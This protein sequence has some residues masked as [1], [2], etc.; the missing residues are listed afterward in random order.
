MQ[1]IESYIIIEFFEW[2]RSR[3]DGNKNMVILREC[4]FRGRHTNSAY[5]VLEPL[6]REFVREMDCPYQSW[7][8][9]QNLKY[10]LNS[11]DVPVK[12]Y[13]KIQAELWSNKKGSVRSPR[14]ENVLHNM[15]STPT[16]VGVEIE[17]FEWIEENRIDPVEI[18]K[19][20]KE[21]FEEM[22]NAFARERNRR[23]SKNLVEKLYSAFQMDI[24]SKQ[25]I[26]YSNSNIV[27]CL[28]LQLGANKTFPN[29]IHNYWDDLHFL[30]KDYLD[31]FY[32]ES[33]LWKSGYIVKEYIHK[34]HVPETAIP[35]LVLWRETIEEAL[36]I[37]LFDLEE[38]EVFQIIQLIV[39]MLK[40][41]YDLE[42]V[43]RETKNMADKK[44]AEKRHTHITNVS[45]TQTAENVYGNMVGN[46]T[47]STI[48]S[49]HISKND[50]K[51]LAKEIE[52][53]TQRINEIAE[54]SLDQKQF[55]VELLEELAA[56]KEDADKVAC[57]KSFAAFV[58]GLGSTADKVISS[59]A[60]LATIA[61]FL[62]IMM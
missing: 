34:L 29:F 31:I 11:E 12:E 1:K 8:I 28:F 60:N 23:N 17:F 54:L 53:A 45:V 51:E 62:G 20:P 49:V 57:K 7:E 43:C 46:A 22:V 5:E 24:L 39:E 44:R 58:K 19:M 6:A 41:N 52:V 30:S 10:Y 16:R 3:A 36:Y 37:E 38:N 42:T 35:C 55:I 40:N 21:K 9:I 14:R 27:K 15:V 26:R 33:E 50:D 2:I 25:Y 48:T 4:C 32:S 56:A 59:L 13:G 18:I 61:G 47:N